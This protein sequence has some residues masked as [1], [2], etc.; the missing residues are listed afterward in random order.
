M[1]NKA[2]VKT[3]LIRKD[4]PRQDRTRQLKVLAKVGYESLNRFR[5]IRRY[6]VK[7]LK[8]KQIYTVSDAEY[9]DLKNKVSDERLRLFATRQ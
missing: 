2:V 9:R 6:E 1:T 5:E 3:N 7:I 8:D 4:F